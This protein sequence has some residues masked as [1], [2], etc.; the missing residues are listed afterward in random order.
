VEGSR[1]HHLGARA[2]CHRGAGRPAAAAGWGAIWRYLALSGAIWRYLAIS[3]YLVL[4]CVDLT[5]ESSALGLSGAESEAK[6]RKSA[7]YPGISRYTRGKIGIPQNTRFVADFAG[8]CPKTCW[9]S[10]ISLKTASDSAQSPTPPER[11]KHLT[12]STKLFGVFRKQRGKERGRE[13]RV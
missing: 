6:L 5:K 4:F 9:S 1:R 8:F 10:K 13:K 3:F 7:N 2:R 11:N 12:I